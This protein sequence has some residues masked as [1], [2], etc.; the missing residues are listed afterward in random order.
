MLYSNLLDLHN[1]NDVFR[2]YYS[3]AGV[4]NINIC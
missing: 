1:K 4:H 3:C 2:K